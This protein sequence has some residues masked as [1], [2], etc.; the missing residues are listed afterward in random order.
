M[1]YHVFIKL[2]QKK[3]KKMLQRNLGS[4]GLKVSSV[5]LG[6]M[7]MSSTYGRA[8]DKESI[9]SIRQSVVNGISL[10]DTANVYGNGH[11]EK[12]LG[13]ALKGVDKQVTV[14]TKVG[15]QE[16]QLNQ[17][18]VNGRPDY[19]RS[20]V[21]NSLIR[22]D[23]EYIDLYYLHRVDPDVP[24]EESIGEMSQLVE[25]GKVKY[26]GISEAS[27]STIK[28]AHQTHPITAVQSEYSLWSR[29]V[30]KEIMPYLQANEIGF[31]AY[32]PLGRGFFADDFSLDASKE[33]VRQY[34]PRFQG[35]NLT[36]NQEVFKVIRNLSQ[37]LGM[38]SSQ[39]ALAWLLQK[40]SNLI[41][42]PGSK[43][44][45]HINENIASSHIDLD[46]KIIHILDKTFD[47]SNTHGSRYPSMLMDELEK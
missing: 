46:D 41:A 11:N 17:K 2:L 19:I 22:L 5:G 35:D 34:L 31:V 33:D 28:R 10:F 12:L 39:L 26:I 16:M 4:Q 29:G 23:R 24:I 32:S 27:L 8:D 36:A 30:E 38:T 21:E 6:C 44:T 13:K 45:Q 18:R 42:I 37:K 15:I 20:E 3:E 40:N 47:E 43:S 9:A 25:E 7:G 1:M 14:A